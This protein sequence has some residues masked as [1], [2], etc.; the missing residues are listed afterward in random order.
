MIT[1]ESK[2]YSK[3]SINAKMK[4]YENYLNGGCLKMNCV[5]GFINLSPPDQLTAIRRRL[6]DFLDYSIQPNKMLDLNQSMSSNNL[7][8]DAIVTLKATSK[9]VTLPTYYFSSGWGA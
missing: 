2:Y 7:N 9:L 5:I 6:S 4:N 1:F 8:E 3:L